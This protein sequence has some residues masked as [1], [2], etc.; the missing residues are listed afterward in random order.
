MGP[1]RINHWQT[2][3]EFLMHRDPG[4]KRVVDR[5]E[6]KERGRLIKAKL[7]TLPQV[8]YLWCIF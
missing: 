8:L 3:A 6:R 5:D 2:V 4:T 7:E 1:E